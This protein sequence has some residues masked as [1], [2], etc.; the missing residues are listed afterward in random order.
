MRIALIS[1]AY[2]CGASESFLGP[3]LD[4][5]AS[6][7]EAVVVYPSVPSSRIR[8]V[9]EGVAIEVIPLFNIT[10]FVRAM[11][12]FMRQPLRCLRILWSLVSVKR[13]FI[14]LVQDLAVFPKAL[15]VA[16]DIRRR[17]ITH[18]HAY[19]LSTPATIAYV[20]AELIRAPYSLTGHRWD[21]YASLGQRMKARGARF[22]RTISCRGA[23]DLRAKV[24][25]A[26]ADR[27]TVVHLGVK[28]QQKQRFWNVNGR[29]R[30]IVPASF[31]PVKDHETLLAALTI[32]RDRKVDFT[33]I[34][35]G[36]G[37]LRLRYEREVARCGLADMVTFS[38]QLA[39]DEL[40]RRYAN[41]ELDVCVLSSREYPNGLMEGVPVALMEAMATG[42]LCVATRTGS[43][44]ELLDD[45]CGLLVPQRNAS[46]LADVLCAI[47]ADPVRARSLAEAG[48]RRVTDDFDV[49]NNSLAL[50]RLILDQPNVLP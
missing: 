46:A 27:V 16:A 36:D 5:L 43:I 11:R 18:V 44:G 1:A 10:T 7:F 45:T 35:A 39:H 17:G 14:S 23:A 29:L 28:I 37:P 41:E 22:T 49:R 32:L 13:S 42:I 8:D 21:I 40:L 9:P 6:T 50:A 26:T 47:T 30:L 15:C 20:A 33:C 3:E 2:P 34:L 4:A 38:G 31:V 24:D 19:W 25:P 48:R 12:A